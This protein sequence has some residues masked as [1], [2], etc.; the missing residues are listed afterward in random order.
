LISEEG[1][2]EPGSGDIQLSPLHQSYGIE[3]G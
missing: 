3:I 2:R 1:K